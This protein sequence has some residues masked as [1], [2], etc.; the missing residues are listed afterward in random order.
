MK[1]LSSLTLGVM[2]VSIFL[3]S[4][5]ANKAVLAQRNLDLAKNLKKYCELNKIQSREIELADSLM[6][7]SVKSLEAGNDE[8]GYW[9]SD[10][11][12]TYYKIGIAQKELKLSNTKLNS[13]KKTLTENKEHLASL[14]E[15]YEEIK[16]LRR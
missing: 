6:R 16:S 4:C 7:A 12:A 8:E 10:I 14:I 9:Q 15:V 13:L 3:F 2:V 11:A 1:K 5:A